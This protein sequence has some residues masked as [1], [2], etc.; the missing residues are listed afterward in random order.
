M[1][2]DFRHSKKQIVITSGKSK[3]GSRKRNDASHSYLPPFPPVGGLALGL[4]DEPVGLE[5]PAG[6][7]Q[8]L[9]LGSWFLVLGSWLLG[10]AAKPEPA[11]LVHSTFTI[12]NSPFKR[13]APS[14]QARFVV[15]KLSHAKPLRRKAIKM[16]LPWRLRGFA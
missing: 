12:L 11:T 3:R 4:M 1:V 6:G 14:T 5:S 10:N 7:Y 16:L 2:R 9:V 13:S 15:N 8:L